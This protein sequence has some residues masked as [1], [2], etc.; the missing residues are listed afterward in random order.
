MKY[1]ILVIFILLIIFP[2]IAMADEKEFID[3]QEK[4]LRLGETF[5]RNDF[6]IEATGFFNNS[7]LLTVYGVENGKIIDSNIM[8]IGDTWNVTNDNILNITILDLREDRGNISAYEGLNVIVDQFVKISTRLAG[9]PLLLVSIVPEEKHLNNRTIV[10]RIFTPG[11]EITINFTINNVGKAKLKELRL[12]INT[13]LPLLFSSDKLNYELPTLEADNETN[14]AV[15]FRAPSIGG[16]ERINFPIAAEATGIDVFGRKYYDNDTTFVIIKPYIEK[17][18]EVKKFIPARVY[19]GD[20][21]YVTLDVKNN[22]YDNV[23]LTLYDNVPSGFELLDTNT[24]NLSL[25]S[26]EERIILYKIRPKI[27]G[28]Y[29][30]SYACINFHNIDIGTECSD[31]P[32]KLYNYKL[33]V[34][35]PYV[36]LI[37]SIEELRENNVDIKIVARNRGDRTAI[38]KLIDHVPYNLTLNGNIFNDTIFKTMII[39]PQ[40]FSEIKY[41]L[42]IENKKDVILPPAE[43]SVSDQFLYLEDRYVQRIISNGIIVR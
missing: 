41:T 20:I 3:P 40:G 1:I 6:L 8:H 2:V 14:V 32:N 24:W 5:I 30:F 4:V 19:M 27:P 22:F 26:N 43:A 9:K 33:I 12:K 36:E 13:T 16:I 35:G 10:N 7:V 38:V 39:R 42:N 25:Y 15:R 31:I 37:K 17:L 28:I 23:D 11:S 34:S 21:I 29:S 18:V